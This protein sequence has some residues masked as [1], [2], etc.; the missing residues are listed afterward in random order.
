MLFVLGTATAAPAGPL[1]G[2]GEAALPPPR[3]AIEPVKQNKCL[4]CQN[5]C[6]KLYKFCVRNAPAGKNDESCKRY[7]DQAHD[8]KQNCK[9]SAACGVNTL[10]S[11]GACK[12]SCETRYRSCVAKTQDPEGCWTDCTKA[13]RSA[14]R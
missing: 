14:C 9:G 5:A 7:F 8:C 6:F 10:Q 1:A 3:P 13:C 12:S 11:C 2:A 4:A